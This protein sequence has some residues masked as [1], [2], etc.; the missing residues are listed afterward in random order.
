MHELSIVE[1]LI[2]QVQSEVEQSGRVGTVRRVDLIIG[3]LS[4]ASCDSI[5]FAF[6]LLKRDTSLEQSD[7]QITEPPAKCH[8][9]S[10]NAE[11][12]IDEIVLS[13]PECAGGNIA[14]EGGRDL[15]LQSIEIEE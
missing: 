15:L 9:R 3:R 1:A 12:E 6:D 11:I 4:G 13:C 5:R 8:C 10:C 7:L 14:I 2:E